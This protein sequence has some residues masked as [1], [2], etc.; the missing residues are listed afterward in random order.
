MDMTGDASLDIIGA[1]IRLAMAPAFLLMGTAA[2]LS[3]FSAR[4]LR[5]V[6]RQRLLVGRFKS[7]E[8]EDRQEIV[9][10]LRDLDK[11]AG[12]VNFAIFMGV[13][14][15]IVVSMVI[16]GLFIVGFMHFDAT[17]IIAVGFILAMAFLIIG[18]MC[19]LIEV[20]FAARNI[21]VHKKWLVLEEGEYCSLDRR[22][23]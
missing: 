4:L 5:V 1:V 9:C 23:L 20:R 10:E 2:M 12:I 13:L 16:A 6:D 14:S 21:H 7:C 11:R 3:L 22:G 19:F 8:V 15:A 18:L 17:V